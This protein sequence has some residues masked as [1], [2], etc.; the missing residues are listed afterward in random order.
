MKCTCVHRLIDAATVR[1]AWAAM[2]TA[3]PA[4][5]AVFSAPPIPPNGCYE[6]V[7]PLLRKGSPVLALQQKIKLLPDN[8]C[9][10][11]LRPDVYRLDFARLS[12]HE[13]S[14]EALSLVFSPDLRGVVGAG[15]HRHR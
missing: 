15:R 2:R 4:K 1:D 11:L 10:S 6:S 8:V 14:G 9:Q 7:D 5:E 12:Q 3:S 13:E